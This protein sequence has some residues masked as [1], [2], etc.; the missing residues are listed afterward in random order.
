[1]R[2]PIRIIGL[3]LDGTLLNNNKRI[4]PRTMAALEAAQAQGVYLVPVTGRPH[5]GVP[6]LVRELPFVRYLISCNGAAIRDNITD[7]FVRERILPPL[8]AQELLTILRRH[9]AP[10]EALYR[11]QGYGEEWVYRQMIAMHPENA[12]LPAYIRDSRLTVPDMAAFLAEGHGPEE[13][14]VMT[15][16]REQRDAIAGSLLEVPGISVVFPAARALEITAAGVDKGEALLYLADHLGVPPQG[17]MAVGDSGNDLA[18]LRAAAFPVA[19]GN[20]APK[21]KAMSK[22]VTATNEEDGVGLA[23]E[24]FVLG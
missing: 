10:H 23:I 3:D 16:S 5:L 12:F 4:S 17:V 21:V 24:E 22:F 15:E 13:L 19:M 7:E 14:F 6:R 20:A 8:L 18:M 1:M 9:G 11:G 2:E